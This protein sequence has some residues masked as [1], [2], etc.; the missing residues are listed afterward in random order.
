MELNVKEVNSLLFTYFGKLHILTSGASQH[1]PTPYPVSHSVKIK[2]LT[3]NR[4]AS[5]TPGGFKLKLSGN[6]LL[7]V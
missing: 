3:F 4:N 6:F 2:N 1:L 7:G 5:K